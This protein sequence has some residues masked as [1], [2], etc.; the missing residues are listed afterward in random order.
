M[1]NDNT[2][3]IYVILDD[4]LQGIHHQENEQRQ[5]NDTMVLT[6]ALIAAWYFAGN[7]TSALGY[8]RAHHCSYV[9]SSSSIII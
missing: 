9:L 5:V 4:I 1:L 8:I 6:T 3:A 7:W 2:I